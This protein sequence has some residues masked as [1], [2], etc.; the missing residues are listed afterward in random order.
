MRLIRAVRGATTARQDE[1]EEILLATRELLTE[2][3]AKNSIRE[4][5]LVSAFFTVTPDLT[6]AFP[7]EAARQV[8]LT[9]LAVIGAVEMVVPGAP[10]FCIRVLIHFYTEKTIKEIRHVY[11]RE[12]RNL[13]PDRIYD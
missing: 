6:A 1:R 11:Q 5:D 12:A 2:I 9:K 7:A 4:E 3:I 13:R 10:R 8:G